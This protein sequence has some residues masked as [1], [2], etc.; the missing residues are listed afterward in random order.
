M[1]ASSESAEFDWRIA[2]KN[3]TMANQ[4]AQDATTQDGAIAQSGEW[5]SVAGLFGNQTNSIRHSPLE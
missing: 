2:K 4:E 5:R 1:C 3:S